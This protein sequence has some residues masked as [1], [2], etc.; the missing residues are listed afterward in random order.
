MKYYLC[1]RPGSCCP[2][3][4][5]DMTTDTVDITDDDDNII[6]MTLEQFKILL[7]TKY[8]FL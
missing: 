1:G 6:S 7:N 5:F 4:E 8:D 3:V 2:N